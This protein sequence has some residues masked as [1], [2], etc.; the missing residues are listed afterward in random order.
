MHASH[1]GNSGTGRVSLLSGSL[2]APQMNP[3]LAGRLFCVR[4]RL[5]ATTHAPS[6]SH[7][8]HLAAESGIAT[9]S[10]AARV[11]SNSVGQ[12]ASAVDLHRGRPT[13]TGPNSLFPTVPGPRGDARPVTCV[14]RHHSPCPSPV[15]PV[16]QYSFAT[17]ESLGHRGPDNPLVARCDCTVQFSFRPAHQ[18]DGRA[19]LQAIARRPVRVA[20]Y[21]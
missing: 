16:F 15:L 11:V 12:R 14:C 8:R 18:P 19:G 17:L 9:R 7:W 2:D 3:G 10:K 20:S 13:V 1:A 6:L 21:L 5:A 4:M